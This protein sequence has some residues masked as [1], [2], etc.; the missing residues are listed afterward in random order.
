[1]LQIHLVA[2]LSF[3]PF[4][5]LPVP[6]TKMYHHGFLLL[7]ALFHL[8]IK[9]QNLVVCCIL[10]VQCTFFQSVFCGIIL[11]LLFDKMV[12]D[13]LHFILYLRRIFLISEWLILSTSFRS[14]IRKPAR[15]RND[16][17]EN[18][19]SKDLGFED[20]ISTIFSSILLSNL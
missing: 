2:L 13:F 15:T 9:V 1:M 3:E 12:L 14:F 10:D 19:K 20:A 11:L 18:P 5:P 4:Q 8:H 6:M 7:L 16:H 17:V